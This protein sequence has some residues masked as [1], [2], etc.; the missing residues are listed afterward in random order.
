MSELKIR[1]ELAKAG[2][3]KEI[4]NLLT[5][6]RPMARRV[7][8]RYKVRDSQDHDDLEQE[9]LLAGHKAIGAFDME[10]DGEFMDERFFAYARRSMENAAICY[11]QQFDV[12]PVPRRLWQIRNKIEREKPTD[13]D[14]FCLKYSISKKRFEDAKSLIVGMDTKPR[15]VDFD[16]VRGDA[17]FSPND[18][19]EDELFYESMKSLIASKINEYASYFDAKDLAI[20]RAIFFQQ[21]SP[22]E[23]A[24]ENDMC[25]SKVRYVVAQVLRDLKELLLD[26]GVSVDDI[27]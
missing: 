5:E 27:F 13:V 21:L 19:V 17:A 22:Q 8:S 18:S 12:V 14:E 7:A 10:Y 16:T 11:L 9:A 20:F 3:T 4:Q 15:S 6:L 25:D 26:D 24:I 1:L 2:H 23:V